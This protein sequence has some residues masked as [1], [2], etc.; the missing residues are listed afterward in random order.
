MP[1]NE[2]KV[3]GGRENIGCV[4]KK[5]AYLSKDRTAKK[6]LKRGGKCIINRK[7]SIGTVYIGKARLSGGYGS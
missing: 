7:H 6:T 2:G 5:I 1:V 3:S 4:V